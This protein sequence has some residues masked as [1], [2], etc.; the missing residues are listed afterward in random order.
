MKQLD[1]LLRQF[2]ALSIIAHVAHINTR[3]G[4]H[5]EA[6]GEFYDSVNQFKDRLAEY[7]VGK[8]MMNKVE[9]PILECN[10]DLLQK[11]AGLASMFCEIAEEVDDEAL[12]NMA[13][14]FEEVV[15]RLSYKMMM[16]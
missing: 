14:E 13:G 7:L 9:V 11:S 4:F 1:V 2:Y 15:A 10:G 6:I 8:R 16:S 5:H 12:C 3:V